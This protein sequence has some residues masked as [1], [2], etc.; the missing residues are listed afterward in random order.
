MSVNELDNNS[1]FFHNFSNNKR[2]LNTIPTIKNMNEVM[3]NSF[4]E[5]AEAGEEVFKNMFKELAGCNIQEIL[6]VIN[7][8]PRMIEEEMNTH[9][10]VE[11]TEEELEKVVYSYQKGKIPG[12]DGLTI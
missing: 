4:K 2:N 6:E 7:L 11:V 9:L 3:V 12:P 10:K 1:K 5:K 8:F